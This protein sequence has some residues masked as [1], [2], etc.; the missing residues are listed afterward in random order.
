VEVAD[1]PAGGEVGLVTRGI[2]F[3]IDAIFV[4]LVGWIVGGRAGRHR[5]AV[6][7]LPTTSRPS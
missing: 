1:T 4:D 6:R 2:A 3:A 7:P 5:L